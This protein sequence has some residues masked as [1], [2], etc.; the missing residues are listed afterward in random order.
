MKPFYLCFAC[1]IVSAT[2]VFADAV[3]P[4]AEAQEDKRVQTPYDVPN[5]EQIAAF[6]KAAGEE[7]P[8]PLAVSLL[9]TQ[10]EPQRGVLLTATSKDTIFFCYNDK[11]SKISNTFLKLSGDKLTP[12]TQTNPLGKR[13]VGAYTVFRPMDDEAKKIFEKTLGQEKGV[14]Y[15]PFAFATQVVAGRNFQFLCKTEEGEG[16][17]KKYFN[18]IAAVYVRFNGEIKITSKETFSPE[19]LPEKITVKRRRLP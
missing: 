19:E 3:P 2:F 15:T 10:P 13:A 6:K 17:E 7:S 8:I 12:I 14:T 9:P 16:K 4:P 1:V 18:V 5:D 11:T